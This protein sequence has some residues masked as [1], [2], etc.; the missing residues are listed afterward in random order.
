M[1]VMPADID[2]TVVHSGNDPTDWAL[3]VRADS[4]LEARRRIPHGGVLRFSTAERNNAGKNSEFGLSTET[5]VDRY[6]AMAGVNI[7]KTLLVAQARQALA[8]IET[9][10][11]TESTPSRRPIIESIDVERVFVEI[12]ERE[13]P[14]WTSEEV[15][16]VV[17]P[18]RDR[19]RTGGNR[20][21][22]QVTITGDDTT[23]DFVLNRNQANQLRDALSRGR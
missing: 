21:I 10:G 6:L 11:E 12:I 9:D 20:V 23:V 1:E 14:I 18:R 8:E 15:A 5:V 3:V 2:T 4:V 7:Q 22:A 17:R 13:E 16:V 19:T